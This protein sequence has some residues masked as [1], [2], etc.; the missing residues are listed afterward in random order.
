MSFFFRLWRV[1]LVIKII[2]C[3]AITRTSLIPQTHR[4]SLSA[5]VILEFLSFFFL[6]PPSSRLP[7]VFDFWNFVSALFS[8]FS[9]ALRFSF[10]LRNLLV[11]SSLCVYNVNSMCACVCCV[12]ELCELCMS[13]C[14]L[15][16]CGM[17]SWW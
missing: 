12:K 7:S 11:I 4:L 2:Q 5:F 6:P 10:T 3:V 8:N 15:R 16:Q 14:V 17:W 13:L 1:S 9:A